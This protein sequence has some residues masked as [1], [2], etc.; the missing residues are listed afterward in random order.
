MDCACASDDGDDARVIRAATSASLIIASFPAHP[1]TETRSHFVAWLAR[2]TSFNCFPDPP[3]F[4]SRPENRA[5][6]P[7]DRVTLR[8][9]V[10]S[11]PSP[12]YLWHHTSAVDGKRRL[13]GE[14][15]RCFLDFSVPRL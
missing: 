4:L 9:N 2:S 14:L 5:G 3:V 8:C 10:D 12:N 1:D 15:L 7:G 11:N 6:Q 13:V